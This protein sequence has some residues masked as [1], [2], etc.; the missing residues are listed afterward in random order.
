MPWYLGLPF[1][2]T[3]SFSPVI[4]SGTIL[5]FVG[6]ESRQQRLVGICD[7]VE[8]AGLQLLQAGDAVR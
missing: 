5:H 6:K 4:A 8:A 1:I 7:E 3:A 2:I